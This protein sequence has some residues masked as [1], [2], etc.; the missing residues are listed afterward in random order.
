MFDRAVYKSIN[1]I[2][3]RIEKLIESGHL[4][5]AKEML[6]KLESKLN[7]DQ[8]IYSM[9]AVV[10]FAEGNLEAAEDTIIKG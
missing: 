4:D 7:Y 6:I 1:N 10:H 3:S 8:D 2:K 9:Q 5:E